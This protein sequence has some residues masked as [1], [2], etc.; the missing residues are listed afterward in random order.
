MKNL[1]R[2]L[3]SYKHIIL[4]LI[5]GVGTTLVNVAVYSLCAHGLELSTTA[6]TCIA[7]VLS[8]LFAYLTNRI[9]VFESRART[10]RALLRE[11][12][13]F[14]ACRLATGVLDLAIMYLC[15]DVLGFH[16]VAVKLLSNVLVVILNYVA[17]KLFVFTKKGN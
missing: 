4:Y 5:F 2:L 7:W 8:V 6:S 17:S 1:M 15:V 9:W 13:S 14:F 10:A 11:A 3:R 12:W 16:D